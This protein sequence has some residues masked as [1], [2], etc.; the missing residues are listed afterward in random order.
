M[1]YRISVKMELARNFL[2]LGSVRCKC[3]YAHSK[4][5]VLEKSSSKSTKKVKPFYS[6]LFLAF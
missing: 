5:E 6:Y 4:Q 3:R 2:L 1:G